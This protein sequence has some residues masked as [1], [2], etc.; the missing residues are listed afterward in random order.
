MIHSRLVQNDTAASTVQ[1]SRIRAMAATAVLGTLLAISLAFLVEAFRKSRS[2]RSRRS[3]SRHVRANGA[4]RESRVESAE[5]GVD[6]QGREVPAPTSVGLA[7]RG[8]EAR[9]AGARD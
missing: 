8:R 7:A 1:G 5:A 6:E 4:A 9:R 3:R 2:R